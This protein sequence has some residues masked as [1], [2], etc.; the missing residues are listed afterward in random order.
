MSENSFF[1]Y[2]PGF[3]TREKL[4]PNKRLGA[5]VIFIGI[6]TFI[7]FLWTL[8]KEY[9]TIISNPIEFV[10]L[11]NE[12]VLA[13]KL[14]EK[15]QM[16][17]TG[18]GFA[19]L[20]HN[21]DISKS[22]LKVDF[23]TLYQGENDALDNQIITLSLQT[24]K[25]RLSTQLTNIDV[26]TIIPDAVSFKF[27]KMI[28]KM[29][30]VKADLDLQIE[31]QY[32]VK[33]EISITPDSVELLGPS[34]ILD[35]ITAIMT[36]PL[37]LKKVDRNIQRNLSL[38]QVHDKVSFTNKRVQIEIPV[39]QYTEKTMEVPVFAYNVPDSMLLKVFPASVKLTFR[40]IV[41]EFENIQAENF[42][43]GVYYNQVSGGT[44]SKLT[45]QLIAYPDFI[46]NIKVSP[47][48]VAY[49]LEN[50]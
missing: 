18:R 30:P 35:T 41:S 13:N 33:G 3:I 17:V 8:E 39:E 50:K 21:W 40:V 15:I 37:K 19:L 34:T 6:A 1:K 44:P 4:R 47:E 46:E 43:L 22:R 26:N 16:E 48:T 27:A 9:T 49:I 24:V 12:L 11:P 32:M 10:N 31:K 45:I 38:Q 42:N 29:V 5:F 25:T 2:I 36:A 20:R 28:K 14:P 23:K 7:W